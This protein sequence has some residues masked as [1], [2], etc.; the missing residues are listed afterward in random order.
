MNCY[1]RELGLERF[2][3][4]SRVRSMLFGSQVSDLYLQPNVGGDV[5]VM[6]ALLKGVIE[7]GAF[8]TDFIAQHTSGWP[9]ASIRARRAALP[10]N[11]SCSW[12]S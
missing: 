11:R 8:D 5:A 10:P 2:R 3:V 7:T 4:P 9:V 12:A 6:K 1:V